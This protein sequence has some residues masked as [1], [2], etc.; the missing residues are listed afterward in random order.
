MTDAPL[1]FVHGILGGRLLDDRGHLRWLGARQALALDRRPLRAPLAWGEAQERDNLVPDGPLDSVLGVPVYARFLRWA[2]TRSADFRPLAYDWRRDLLESVERLRALLQA[3]ADEHGRPPRVVAH[4]MG[5]L[6]TWLLLRERPDLA[7]GVLFAGVP[8]GAGISFGANMQ[9]GATFG[10]NRWLADPTAFG[11]WT[12][13]YTFFPAGDPQ[14]EGV[15]DHRWHDPAAWERNGLGVFGDPELDPAPWRAHLGRAL[16]CA[17]RTR[18][19]LDAPHPDPGKLP[20]LAVL[21]GVGRGAVQVA[22]RGGPASGHGWDFRSGRS[23]D[24]D[25]SV[26][27]TLSFP[28]GDAPVRAGTSRKP[29]QQLLDDLPAVAAL[30]DGLDQGP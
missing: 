12:A 29:H 28:P 21:S 23:V 10:V 15:D 30:L 1:V 19:L 22:L 27:A 8:F 3:M 6:I 20:P 16:A 2:G 25:G 24:G 5:G 9:G 14:V 4:S 18:A 26:A 17:A 13:P 7:S 11:S